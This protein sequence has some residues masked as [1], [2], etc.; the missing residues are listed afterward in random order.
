ML[1]L[2]LFF[3]ARVPSNGSIVEA[4]L[5]HLRQRRGIAYYISKSR[6]RDSVLSRGSRVLS[7]LL[8]VCFNPWPIYSSYYVQDSHLASQT[9]HRL[10]ENY[11]LKSISLSI[12]SYTIFSASMH[13]QR[14]III[15]GCGKQS[16]TESRKTHRFRPSSQ[17]Y[18]G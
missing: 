3:A 6:S 10:T 2:F 16:Q 13:R 11:N 17:P 18:R 12:L 4:P 1:P 14:F 15:K 9:I 7:S 5:S 8:P